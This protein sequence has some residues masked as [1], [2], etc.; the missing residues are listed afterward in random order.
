[1]IHEWLWRIA[2]DPGDVYDGDTLRC[3]IDRGFNDVSANRKIR[4]AGIDTPELRGV[5]RA[6]GLQARDAAHDWVTE[7]V[8]GEAFPFRMRTV[9]LS[10]KYGRIVATVWRPDDLQSLNAWLLEHGF[11]QEV[12]W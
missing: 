6:E 7:A 8:T 1:M 4:L 11:A 2:I 5:E 10:G 3:T 12:D 9:K